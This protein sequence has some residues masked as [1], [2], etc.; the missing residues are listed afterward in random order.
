M[1]SYIHLFLSILLFAAMVRGIVSL[2][3]LSDFSSLVYRNEK[4]F[5]I[6]ISHPAAMQNSLIIT[7]SVWRDLWDI[8]H[9]ISCHLQI[10]TVLLF[11]SMDSGLF[12]FL[13]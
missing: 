12:P 11:S 8:L 6:L 9:V 4:D 2:I 3:S 10:V 13:V 5:C 7:S 1:P